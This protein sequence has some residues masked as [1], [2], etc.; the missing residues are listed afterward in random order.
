MWTC[1][2]C[3]AEKEHRDIPMVD[4][5][6]TDLPNISSAM[7][8]RQVLCAIC[9][10]YSLKASRVTMEEVA[11]NDTYAKGYVTA[12]WQ[13]NACG[14]IFTS[15]YSTAEFDAHFDTLLNGMI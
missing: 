1:S 13:C 14:H 3:G 2:K 7:F 9:N 6:D 8:T 5:K 10:T 15:R 4:I 11:P 12:E